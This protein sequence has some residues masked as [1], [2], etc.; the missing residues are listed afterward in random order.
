M[1]KNVSNKT[2]QEITSDK[3]SKDHLTLK[4]LGINPA[5]VKDKMAYFIRPRARINYY[6]SLL[7]EEPPTALQTEPPSWKYVLVVSFGL[8]VISRLIEYHLSLHPLEGRNVQYGQPK[9][10]DIE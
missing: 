9:Y 7:G 6:R 10:E 5:S 1:Y 2:F 4:D 3:V 8:L